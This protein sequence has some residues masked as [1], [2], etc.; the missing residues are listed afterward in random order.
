MTRRLDPTPEQLARERAW[1]R[2]SDGRLIGVLPVPR[3]TARR[4]IGAV[5]G[6][7]MADGSRGRDPERRAMTRPMF[8]ATLAAVRAAAPAWFR[9][10]WTSERRQLATL[11]SEGVLE[12]RVAG[13]PSRAAYEYREV[14]P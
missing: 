3:F 6:R 13:A 10:R 8:E 1:P 5:T 14:K 12:R 2:S 4:V 11:Y 7:I 9:G